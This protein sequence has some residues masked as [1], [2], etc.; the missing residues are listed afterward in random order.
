MV[1]RGKVAPFGMG[2]KEAIRFA[3]N[4]GDNLIVDTVNSEMM[5]RVAVAINKFNNASSKQTNRMIRLTEWIK[6]LTIFLT[7]IGLIRVVTLVIKWKV[8]N[9]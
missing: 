3:Y 2:A 6:W 8:S 9:P 4:S 1:K 5:R 7:L